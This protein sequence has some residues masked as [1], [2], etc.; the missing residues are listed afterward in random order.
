[1]RGFNKVGLVLVMFFGSGATALIYEVI[2]SKFLSQ[3]FGSTIYAQTV[4]LATFMGGLAL[5]NKL[6]GRRADVWLRPLRAYGYLEMMIGLYAFFFPTLNQVADSIFVHA[7]SGIGQQLVWL[8]VLKGLLSAALLLGPTILMGGTLPLMSAWLKGCTSDAGRQSALFYG[9]NSLGAV[10]GSWMAGFWLVQNLGMISALQITALVNLLLGATALILGSQAQA[11]SPAVTEGPAKLPDQIPAGKSSLTSAAWLVALTGAVSMGLEVLASRSLAMIFGS[12]LQSFAIV[13]MAFILGIGLGSIWITRRDSVRW[14]AEKVM[15]VSLCLAAGW[16]ILLVFNIAGWVDS[17]RLLQTGLGRTSMGYILHEG[18]TALMALFIFGLPAAAIGCVLPMMIRLETQ[19]H[20]ALGRQ[21]GALLTW[22][23]LGAVGGT[24]LTGFVLMPALGIRNAFAALCLTLAIVAA[25]LAWRSRWRKGMTVSAGTIL[26][27]LGL[28][29][30]GGEDWRCVISAGAFRARE[31]EFDPNAMPL[32]RQFTKILFYEDGPDATVSVEEDYRN[33]DQPERGI[34]VNGK[35]DATSHSDLCTQFLISHLP[36][37]A[38]PGSQQV[39]IFGLGSGISAGTL[40]DYPLTRLTVA[41]NCEPVI[42]ASRYFKEWNHDVLNDPHVSLWREDAR[43]VLKLN[44]QTYDVIIAQPSNPWTAGIGSVFSR[45]FYALAAGRLK[46]GGIM[47][48]WFHVY[49]MHDGIVSLV[50]RTFC[51]QFPYVEIWDTGSGD[52]VML[53][54]EQPWTSNP[55][56]FQQ[57][58]ILPA[59]Q[60]DLAKIGILSPA[61]LWARQLASQR[62]AFAISGPGPIQS[63]LFP[64]LEYA[65]PRAFYVGINAKLFNQFDE[66]TRQL[67]LAPVSKR[68]TLAALS[69][70][71]ILTSLVPYTSINEQLLASLTAKNAEPMAN[72]FTAPLPASGKATEAGGGPLGAA[73]K[74]FNQGEY[75]SGLDLVNAYLD[76]NP[77]NSDAAYLRRVIIGNTPRQSQPGPLTN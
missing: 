56:V 18:L 43:T 7:G 77:T 64:I 22:N 4:V 39:F 11:H 47:A 44:P 26:A 17:Y 6:I 76:R 23:T 29:T 12:S 31:V 40:L 27:S 30:I 42:K 37:L 54:S 5:G 38:R 45:E 20:P 14:P 10:A 46:P 69:K 50:L 55:E 57:G 63:D 2:W 48:Q 70:T 25:G 74:A 41:E 24:L 16:I 36:M 8:L 75:Q 62:T 21:V 58:F 15:I 68:S 61:G 49:E 3:M 13:L 33:P 59:V 52:I 53:G 65:A 51:E 72:I 34:R 73:I 35:P 60:A 9:V 1:M 67:S 19:K 71:D 66:R 32:R 28:L